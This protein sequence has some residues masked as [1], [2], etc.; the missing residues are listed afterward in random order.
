M[1]IRTTNINEYVTSIDDQNIIL[2]ALL[3]N[4]Q[5]HA[6]LL[7]SGRSLSLIL[8]FLVACLLSLLSLLFGL[9]IVSRRM[10]LFWG[11]ILFFEFFILSYIIIRT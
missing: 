5:F 1:P 3:F 10:S 9:R 6:Y 11:S 4:F 2:Y 8:S 7:L